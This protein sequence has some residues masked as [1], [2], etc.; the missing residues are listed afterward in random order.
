MLLEHILYARQY[1]M[2][3]NYNGFRRGRV[4]DKKNLL[5]SEGDQHL[6]KQPFSH[7][8]NKGPQL[9]REVGHLPGGS[10]GRLSWRVVWEE[11]KHVWRLWSYE[12]LVFLGPKTFV[13]R[14]DQGLN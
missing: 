6:N 5:C 10:D 9:C 7:R 14:N 2:G 1:A 11:K 8:E 13:V 4:P 3:W 12:S